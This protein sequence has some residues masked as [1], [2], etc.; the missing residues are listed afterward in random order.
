[1][2]VI[3]D[4]IGAS[5]SNLK[6]VYKGEVKPNSV[7][8]LSLK[9]EIPDRTSGN[10]FDHFDFGSMK[11]EKPLGLNEILATIKASKTG[12]QLLMPYQIKLNYLESFCLR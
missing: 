8:R 5:I 7:L 2:L 6:N 11:T 1:M 3:G 4:I 9:N 10:P 12:V